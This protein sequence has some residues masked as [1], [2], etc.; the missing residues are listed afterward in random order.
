[1]IV[2]DDYPEKW[3]ADEKSPGQEWESQDRLIIS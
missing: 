3:L 1:M 2:A